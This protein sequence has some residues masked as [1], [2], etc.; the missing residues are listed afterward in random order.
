[1]RGAVLA[2]MLLLGTAVDVSAR[3]EGAAQHIASAGPAAM[4]S[5]SP[6]GTRII[7]HSRRKDEKQKGVATRNVWSVAADGSNEKR[8]TTGTKDE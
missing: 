2:A 3:D 7:F 8:L 5:W 4:P 1:M 6:D